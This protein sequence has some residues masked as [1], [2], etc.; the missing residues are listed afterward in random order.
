MNGASALLADRMASLLPQTRAGACVPASPYSQQAH[1]SIGGG[2]IC[3]YSRTC[4]FSCHG[5][6]VCGSWRGLYCIDNGSCSTC[7]GGGF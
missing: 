5:H 1:W 6:V 3:Y 4:R 2:Q 7:G